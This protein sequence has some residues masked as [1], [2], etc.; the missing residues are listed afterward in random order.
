MRLGLVGDAGREALLDV[1]VQAGL[2]LAGVDGGLVEVERA[3]PHLEEVFDGF[4]GEVHRLRV[5]V[6]PEVLGAVAA[7]G[8]G[9]E[10]AGEALVLDADV[11]VRLV[12]LEED[13]VLRLDLLDEVVLQDQ[14]LGLG[15][16]DDDLD[17]DDAATGGR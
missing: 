11:G 12:V 8:A 3:G 7:D 2:E 14:R 1:V 13:V 4:E 5:R 9:G 16:G 10:D 17:V 6:R 15:V